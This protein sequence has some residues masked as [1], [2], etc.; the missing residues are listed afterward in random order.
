[1]NEYIGKERRRSNHSGG[2]IQY[3]PGHE[4]PF[5]DHIISNWI[6]KNHFSNVL[7]LGGGGFRFALPA[8]EYLE[9]ITVVDIDKESLN[10]QGIIKKLKDI[11]N[12]SDK[13]VLSKID[14]I[15]SDI[16]QYLAETSIK[17][18]LVVISRLLH[19]FSPA[20]INIFINL[21]EKVTIDQGLVCV[22]ALCLT[23][24]LT[25][26]FNEFFLNSRENPSRYFRKMNS[27]SKTSEM[28]KDQNL[29]EQIHLFDQE[30]IQQI[31]G[32]KF[33]LIDGPIWA[34]R[35]VQGFIFRKM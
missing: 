18:D 25:G 31:F 3:I 33:K 19:L 32:E 1:M 12:F 35:T 22:S 29:P 14:I 9:K 30:Y 27:D 2:G 11:G 24:K 28:L 10:L 13:F 26:Q 17:F 5:I 21:L 15:N 7:D 20:Q 8:S 34:T 23:D 4:E 6:V 16:F